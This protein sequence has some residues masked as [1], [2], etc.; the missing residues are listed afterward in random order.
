MVEQTHMTRQ[1]PLN[2]PHLNGAVPDQPAGVE[3][4]SHAAASLPWCVHQ[5]V[6]YLRDNLHRAITLENLIHAAETSERTLHRQFRQAIGMTPWAYLRALRLAAAR[7]ALSAR[8]DDPITS[9]AFSVGYTHHSRFACEYRE[10]FGEPPSETRRRARSDEGAAPRVHVPPRQRPVLS[11]L[12]LHTITIEERQVAHAISEHLAA[13]LSRSGVASVNLVGPA[14]MHR[15][16]VD[17]HYSLSGRLTLAGGKMRLT[18]RLV[19]DVT[20]YHVWADS[21]DGVA[22]ELFA[23]QDRVAD[24]VVAGVCPALISAEIDRLTARPVSTLAAREIAF[25]A[26]PFALAADVESAR[27]LLEATQEA[28]DADLADT[29]ALS[30]AALGHAQIAFYLGTTAP[31]ES[32]EQAI[33]FSQHAAALSDHDALSLTALAG[34]AAALGRPA[35]EIERLTIRALAIDPT[36]G[37]AW[38]R[39]G[40][41]RLGLGQDPSLALA[42]FHR[43]SRLNGPGMPRAN[44]L[45]GLSRVSLAV[46]SR[47]NNV[48]YSLQALAA[49]PRAAWI[50]VNLICAYHAAGELAA[51]RRSLGGLRTACPDLTLTLFADCRPW[52]PAECLEILHDAGL[53]LN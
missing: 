46:G 26:L 12:P 45:N 15:P 13:A 49:N 10:R 21:F 39:M 16:V 17:R 18:I 22:D 11:I 27:H 52:L 31:A 4:R 34:A 29:L 50:Q 8:T 36:L 1:I 19:N 41:V 9:I 47:P 35:E 24:G 5:A 48:S 7:R 6:C 30:L 3:M 37:W 42:D 25:R 44:I 28:L 40:F 14:I 23:M 33:R 53:P 38:L 20:G 51:M 2:A 43:A 32:R